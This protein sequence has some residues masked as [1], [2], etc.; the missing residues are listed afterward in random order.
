[1]LAYVDGNN[2]WGPEAEFKEK[3][4]V[5]DPTPELTKTSPYVDSFHGQPYARVD[6]NLYDFFSI[7]NDVNVAMFRIRMFWASRIR[8]R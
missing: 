6:I 2:S 7:K 4:G 3:H 5:R 1:V 8:I